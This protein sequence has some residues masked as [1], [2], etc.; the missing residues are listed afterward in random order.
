MLGH[1]G[2]GQEASLAAAS[3]QERVVQEG[4]KMGR[5]TLGSAYRLFSSASLILNAMRRHCEVIQGRQGYDLSYIY[6]NCVT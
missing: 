2:K 3:A 5:T 1:T 4:E 6:H